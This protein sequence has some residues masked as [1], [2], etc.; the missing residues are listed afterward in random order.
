MNEMR[1]NEK[2]TK[3]NKQ[4]KQTNERE[5]EKERRTERKD[6]EK[7]EREKRVARP[8]SRRFLFTSFL[9]PSVAITGFRQ[10]WPPKL[11]KTR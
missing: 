11:G 10:I 4:T 3:K 7:E 6:E 8:S 2:G 9:W 5:K 1:R